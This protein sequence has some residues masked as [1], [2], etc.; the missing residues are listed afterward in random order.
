MTKIKKATTIITTIVATFGLPVS[1]HQS[2]AVHYHYELLALALVSGVIAA[3][4]LLKDRALKQ[5]KRVEQS[6]QD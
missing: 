4:M 6:R 1:A 5:Q 2:A 3:R